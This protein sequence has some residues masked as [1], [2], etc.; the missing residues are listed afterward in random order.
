MPR[1]LALPL[2]TILHYL[3]H[4]T[5]QHHHRPTPSPPTSITNTHPA[6]TSLISCKKSKSSHGCTNAAYL[7][8]TLTWWY[9]IVRMQKKTIQ[10]TAPFHDPPFSLHVL[11][12]CSGASSSAEKPCCPIGGL[13]SSA[14]AGCVLMFAYFNWSSLSEKKKRGASASIY[15]HSIGLVTYCAWL[16]PLVLLIMLK[17]PWC[18][19]GLVHPGCASPT[20]CC[21]YWG[22][23]P[24]P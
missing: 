3:L 15:T 24:Y 9:R 1:Q 11:L 21:P 8:F 5:M 23:E 7:P 18:G 4:H 17:C 10:I 20:P 16:M 19:I 22:G 6:T 14:G 13:C 2:P 12:T